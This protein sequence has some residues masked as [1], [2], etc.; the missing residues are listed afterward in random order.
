M[1]PKEEKGSI[2][3][4]LILSVVMKQYIYTEATVYV[5]LCVYKNKVLTWRWTQKTIAEH[6]VLWIIKHPHSDLQRNADGAK[7][8][9]YENVDVIFIF[10]SFLH[11]F[12]E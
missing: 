7:I 10:L 1:W 6:G 4:T 9:H 8:S 3:E 12:A 5:S 11:V 2:H